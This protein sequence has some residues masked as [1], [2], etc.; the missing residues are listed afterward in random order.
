MG[1]ISAEDPGDNG[2][3]AVAP[4]QLLCPFSGSPQA[5]GWTKREEGRL[6]TVL[7]RQ[8]QGVRGF[9][10]KHFRWSTVGPALGRPGGVEWK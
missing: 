3:C 7:G 8:E 9:L 2:D 6:D 10:R 4:A 1:E 5:P